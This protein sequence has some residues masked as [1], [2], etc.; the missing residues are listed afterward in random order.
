MSLFS[1]PRGK[2]AQGSNNKDEALES[3]ELVS[4]AA[5][6]TEQG[7][8]PEVE[9]ESEGAEGGASSGA[10][11]NADAAETEDGL[12]DESVS[13]Q[14]EAA[15]SGA[16]VAAGFGQIPA[17]KR[18]RGLKA[19]GIA[20]GV[21][22]AVLLVVYIV[23]AVVFMGRF[24]PNTRIGDHD[25][26][27]KTDAEVVALL[28][29]IAADYQLDV[30]GGGFAYRTTGEG[31]GLSIDSAG[32][33]RAIHEDENP[34]QWPWLI[35]QPN[36][37][38]TSRMAITFSPNVYEADVT[39]AVAK[40]NETAKPPV[41]ATIAYDEKTGKFNVKPEE[42]GTQLDAAAVLASMAK[43]I[44]QLDTKLALGEEHLIKP[45]V[46]STDEKLIEAAELATGMVSAD[47]SLVMGG[48]SVGKVTGDTLSAFITIN[49]NYEVVFREEEMNAWVDA[50]AASFNTVGTERTYTRADGKAVVVPAGGSYGWE[51]DTEALKN[52]VLEGVK[53]GAVTTIEVPCVDTAAVYNGVGQRDWGNRYLDVDISEQ[54]VRFYG[55]DGAIIWET[56]FISGTPDGTHDTVPG[57]W[58]VNS[59][60]SPSKLIGY[61]N[62]KKIY[63]TTVTYW[64]P[65]EGNGIGFHD[66]T[67]QPGFGGTMYAN[68]YGSH[69]CVNLSYAAAQELYGIV[70]V[71]DV[72]VVHY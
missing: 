14:V 26:S 16:F 70:Q 29:G 38:E 1:K 20:V 53:A 47:L 64:M 54:H 46:L 10:Q 56:D 23:G 4:P 42:A 62:G 68:G 25:I 67:W 8:R 71:G 11:A 66:A 65:F 57:T 35:A 2:H 43:T 27:M 49:E 32:I 60:E 21:I 44:D 31:I 45:T 19:F 30:L 6:E 12:S 48:Q 13:G 33:V 24:L 7:E 50:L 58:Y 36:H 28:D 5:D 18:R 9:G 55:D 72:V 34:W 39:E 15:E 51:V 69:G 61:E 37:D 63:E 52:A 40:F 41:N 22:A 59:K 3:P 17:E